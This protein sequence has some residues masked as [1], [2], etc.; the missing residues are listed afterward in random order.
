MYKKYFVIIFYF[1]FILMGTLSLVFIPNALAYSSG[2]ILAL[3]VISLPLLY[4]LYS[5]LGLR[6][7][8]LLVGS[9]STLALLIEY[10]GLVTGWP[11]GSFI[12]TGHLGC[13]ILGIL[14]WTV[15][16]SWTPLVIG[17]VALVYANTR[18]KILRIILP[19]FLLVV[20]DLLLDPVAVHLGMWSYVYGGIYYSVPIQNFVGWIFSGLIGS[21]MCFVFLDKLSDKKIYQL[22][23]SFF[24]SIVFW[25]VVSIG[26]GLI[27]PVFFGLCLIVYSIVIYY[28]NNEKAYYN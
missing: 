2:S 23:Y 15:G 17:S 9:L 26:L 21:L 6:V 1:L 24:I 20:F 25:T 28:K 16:L 7:M 19:V 11:Y 5:K 8:M 10:I 4:F 18:I 3:F 22:A 13:K 12:Y 14:P 27:A